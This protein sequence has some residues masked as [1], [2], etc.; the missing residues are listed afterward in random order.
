MY[1][2][3]AFVGLGTQ[4]WYQSVPRTMM[5][6]FPIWVALANFTRNRA[7][8]AKTYLAVS[9]SLAVVVGLLYLG[10]QWAG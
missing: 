7:W 5:I 10:G 1:C 8:I 3:L 2:G 6:M 9:G 4:T